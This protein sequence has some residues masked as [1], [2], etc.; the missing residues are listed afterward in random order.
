MARTY[1]IMFTAALHVGDLAAN[2]NDHLSR[3]GLLK[4]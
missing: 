1:F 3:I 2:K 4:S